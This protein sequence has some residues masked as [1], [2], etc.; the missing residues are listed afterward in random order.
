MISLLNNNM[1][2][3]VLTLSLLFAFNAFVIAQDEPEFD[4]DVNDVPV[5]GGVSLLAAA[6]VTYGVR[7]IHNKNKDK[8]E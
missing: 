7:K 8:S 2:K 5:D 6:A 4:D 1:K 3:L